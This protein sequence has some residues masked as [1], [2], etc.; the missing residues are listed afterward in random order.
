MNE[1]KII[2][3][4]DHP[5]FRGGLKNII[6]KEPNIV[7][8]A[9]A[10]TGTEALAKIKEQQPDV[11]VLDLDMPE[12]DGFGVARELQKLRLLT[13]VIILTMHKDEAHFN[14]A[15]DLGVSGFV[16]KDGAA[17]EIVGCIKAVA[18]N[19]E[20]FSPAVSSH[21]LHRVRRA[22][23]FNYQAGINDLTV[24]ER[25]ILFLLAEL[26]TSKEIAAG[27][28]VSPRTIENHRARI[29]QKLD[30]QGSHALVKFALQHKD[31]LT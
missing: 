27:L 10:E 29:C 7:I 26:K 11:A 2:I 17:S 18:A 8:V 3:A 16:V 1:I 13:K 19:R 28:G 4:D 23:S 9:E 21:L 5:I 30:L 6:E 20:Y 22:S 24:T 31:Q 14:R 12:L 25:R 15:I